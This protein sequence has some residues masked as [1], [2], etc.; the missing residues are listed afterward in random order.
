MTLGQLA[1]SPSHLTMTTA[2]H[3]HQ[4]T[5][6]TLFSWLPEDW[7]PQTSSVSKAQATWVFLFCPYMFTI[8]VCGLH[9]QAIDCQVN[10]YVMLRCNSK[11][12]VCCVKNKIEY[13][14]LF[15]KWLMA[16]GSGFTLHYEWIQTN[17]HRWMCLKLYTLIICTFILT[18]YAYTDKCT[19]A[20]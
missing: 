11:K 13:P 14:T 9:S 20:H 6:W 7:H 4:Q 15:Y 5:N 3:L 10:N 19:P 2:P 1:S 12:K 17:A 8:Q 16:H 18:M